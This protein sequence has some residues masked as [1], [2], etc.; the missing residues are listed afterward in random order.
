MLILEGERLDLYT[1]ALASTLDP[2]Q[3][4]WG[5][6]TGN[7]TCGVGGRGRF[8]SECRHAYS[9]FYLPVPISSLF[10]PTWC[11]RIIHSLENC[12]RGRI[13]VA[14]MQITAACLTCEWVGGRSLILEW[15]VNLM[16]WEL[17]TYCGFVYMKKSGKWATDDYRIMVNG[18]QNI[19]E[20]DR[21]IIEIQIVRFIRFINKDVFN[22]EGYGRK[23]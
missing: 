15:R 19:W 16:G 7:V 3:I 8:L 9:L 14:S 20:E 4:N 2:Y 13:V 17:F 22:I 11:R 6:H 21:A 18:P 23:Y 10:W 1:A 5:V 12:L